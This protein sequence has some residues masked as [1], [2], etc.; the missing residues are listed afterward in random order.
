MVEFSDL[1]ESVKKSL[2]EAKGLGHA[3]RPLRDASDEWF[4]VSKKKDKYGDPVN[5][6][7]V[8]FED[9][10]TASRELKTWDDKDK[11]EVVRGA[12]PEDPTKNKERESIYD[13]I[14]PDSGSWSWREHSPEF[15]TTEWEDAKSGRA[16]AKKI[17]KYSG[18]YA[19]W[20]SEDK[21]LDVWR[22]K[23]SVQRSLDKKS[24]RKV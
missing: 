8:G 21:T 5:V 20:N 18:W 2:S 22:P 19:T 15:I 14:D 11:F 10:K 7:L 13:I 1:Y 24:K 12:E 16:L 23:S 3:K 9:N 17:N 4:I 6:Y